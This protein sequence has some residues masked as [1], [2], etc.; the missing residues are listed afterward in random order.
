MLTFTFIITKFGIFSL[1]I[2]F[3]IST[4]IIVNK[5]FGDPYEGFSLT[6]LLILFLFSLNTFMIGIIGEYVTRIYDEVKKRPN[7]I[8]EEIIDTQKNS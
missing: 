8:I 6:I 2:V 1:V 5:F 3:I 4:F 7:Y